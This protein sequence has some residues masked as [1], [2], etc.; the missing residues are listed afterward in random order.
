MLEQL[1]GL[2]EALP[3]NERSLSLIINTIPTLLLLTR[4]PEITT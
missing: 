3:S 4:A 1:N 2:D